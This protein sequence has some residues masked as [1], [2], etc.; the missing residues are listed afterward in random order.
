[1]YTFLRENNYDSYAP[2]PILAISNEIETLKLAETY[3][4]FGQQVGH[5]NAGDASIKNTD[6]TGTYY[7][8][9]D[10][11]RGRFEI[12]EDIDFDIDVYNLTAEEINVDPS[13]LKSF[14]EKWC[15]E[16]ES[17]NEVK[18]FDYWD[19]HNWKTVITGCEFG[20]PTHVIVSENADEMNEAIE[21]CEFIEE[22]HG[23][24]Y[25]ESEKYWIIQSAWQGD[26]ESYQLFSKS[27]YDFDDI[28]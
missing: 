15:E 10:A 26:F 11:V 8:L 18:G 25:F 9:L 19:G 3:D 6:Y 28:K 20:E 27:E 7:D 16:N 12:S 13:E 23:K 2:Q 5:T 21:T 4:R 1:M 14:C 24:Q 22:T 17:F